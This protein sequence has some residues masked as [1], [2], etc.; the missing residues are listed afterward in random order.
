M[1]A[2]LGKSASSEA[3]V[4]TQA[5]RQ[6]FQRVPPI[7][8]GIDLVGKT[9]LV[10]GSNV[11]LGLECARHFLALRPRQ[12]IMATRSLEKGEAAAAQLRAQFP[13]ASI[14]VMHLDMASVQSVQAFAAQCRREVDG[15][16]DVAVLNAGLATETFVRVDEGRGRETTLQVNYLSTAL[17]SILLLPKMMPSASS[18]DPAR[19]SIVTS[20]ASLGAKLKDPGDGKSILDSIDRDD[21][22]DGFQR[23]SESK[24]LVNMFA[25]K[26]AERVPNQDCVINFCNPGAT[27]GTAF[28][29]HIETRLMKVVFGLILG[30]LGRTPVDASRIY[31][32][33]TLVLGGESH[34]SYTDWLVRPWPIFMY[35]NRL[36]DKLWSETM[37]ELRFANVDGV[38]DFTPLSLAFFPAIYL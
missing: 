17:L 34:G 2:Q 31:V 22:S 15:R 20:D 11:G 27:K 10:T 28:T 18:P 33:A 7:P 8:A 29:R 30:I 3:S 12:L 37:E 9:V 21:T 23:Y 13:A 1:S 35:S 6:L 25:A 19:L 36:G 4:L 32:H 5:S 16:I 26:L 24:L 38:L 14:T